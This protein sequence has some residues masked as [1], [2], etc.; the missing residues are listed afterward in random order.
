VTKLFLGR[1]WRAYSKT[2]FV[3]CELP[4][5]IAPEGWNNWSNPENE[6][7]AYYAEYKNTGEGADISKRVGWSKQLSDKEAKDYMLENIFSENNP[8]LPQESNWFSEIRTKPFE[9]PTEKAK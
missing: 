5:Q 2:V 1:P 4:K 3:R 6:K 8:N 9:W 7:T